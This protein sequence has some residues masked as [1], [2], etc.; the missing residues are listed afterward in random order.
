MNLSRLRRAKLIRPTAYVDCPELKGWLFSEEEEARLKVRGLNANEQL[1]AR[2]ET[3]KQ[4]KLRL[5]AQHIQPGTPNG[6]AV[7]DALL[8]VIGIGQGEHAQSLPYLIQLCLWGVI[9]EDGK[10]LLDHELCAILH[11]HFPGT[12]LLLTNTIAGL[13]G[14]PSESALG[15]P[16]RLS[17]TTQE[18]ESRLPLA[19]SSESHSIDLDMT[20]SHM[21]TSPQ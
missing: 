18:S 6:Q 13:M 5:T 4:E 14:Q 3:A 11:E 2:E 15:E 19:N 9:D 12:F 20:S 1:L 8:S 17:G 21:T 10:R 7:K 16:S